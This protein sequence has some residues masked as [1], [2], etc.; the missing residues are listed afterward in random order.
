M[1]VV[2]TCFCD[3][4][5]GGIQQTLILLL[6]K[7]TNHKLKAWRE[8]GELCEFSGCTWRP[9]GKKTLSRFR[10]SSTEKHFG[11]SRTSSQRCLISKKEALRDSIWH[12]F[13]NWT[14]VYWCCHFTMQNRYS[15]SSHH[16]QDSHRLV[17]ELGGFHRVEFDKICQAVHRV[18]KLNISWHPRSLQM[19]MSWWF[20]SLESLL[21]GWN[22]SFKWLQVVQAVGFWGV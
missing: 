5:R 20:S 17:V 6:Q 13:Q 4:W 14:R 22:S 10:H 9:G 21:P 16:V 2:S 3:V 19:M 12:G 18:T 7:K 11:F 15:V 8:K 1:L